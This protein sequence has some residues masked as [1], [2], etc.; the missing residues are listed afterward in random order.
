M[1]NQGGSQLKRRKICVMGYSRVG[2]S[3]LTIQFVHNNFPDSYEPTI[4]N[5]FNKRFQI[6]NVHYS[7]EV[8]IPGPGDNAVTNTVSLAGDGH[9]RAG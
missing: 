4:A 1:S 3:S 8:T 6:N 7:V 5:V 2:K 9:R